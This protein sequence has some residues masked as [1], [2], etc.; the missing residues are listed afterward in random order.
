MTPADAEVRELAGPALD[1]WDAAAVDAPGGHVYQSRAW[2][3]HRAASGWVPRHLAV[4]DARA[5]V[6]V[7]RWPWLPGGSAYVPRGPVVP[8][9]PW[10]PG[11]EAGAHTGTALASIA[12][13]LDTTG[14]DVLAADPEVSAADTAYG[15]ALASAG[16]HAIPEIQPSRH[17]MALALPADGD[18]APVFDGIAKATRQRIRRAERDGVVVVRHDTATT[19]LD[20][21]VRPTEDPDAALDRFYT[22]LRATGDRR[23]FGFAGPEEFL[24]W[25]R[26]ALAAAHLVYLE[27]H[28]G[29]A[30]GDVL[31]GLLLYRHGSRLSTQHSADR[32]ERRRD[33]PGAMHLLRWRAI[34]LAVAE[35]RS[36]MDLGGVDVAGA[37]RI[38]VE[39]EPTYGLYEHKRSFGAEW[40]AMAGAQERVSRAWRYAA[41][42]ATTKLARSLGRGSG[43]R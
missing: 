26:R 4:G 5:L 29:A 3:E 11:G 23:G 17:R 8:G 16:F 25:W 38:P 9:T 40:V 39:G 18:S 10:V 20:G 43:P 24:T 32:A 34:Q 35:R 21:V 33:H 1:G 41:G 28:E 7:R 14:V 42:R 36:E 15:A 31:G 27:A 37:R 2:G 12:A 13:H 6:L 22:L 19:E 30:D